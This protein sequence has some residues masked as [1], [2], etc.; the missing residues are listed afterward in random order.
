VT[1]WLLNV[2][3]FG[4]SDTFIP[5][6]THTF[7]LSISHRKALQGGVLSEVINLE[8]DGVHIVVENNVRPHMKVTHDAVGWLVKSLHKDAIASSDGTLP[9]IATEEYGATVESDAED[10]VAIELAD[11]IAAIKTAKDCSLLAW[12][13][14]LLYHKP[15]VMLDG[16]L[17]A[18]FNRNLVRVVVVWQLVQVPGSATCFAQLCR[19]Y[20]RAFALRGRRMV[21]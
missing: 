11:E 14:S 3:L 1:R 5:N 20:R 8:F 19:S 17:C 6:S 18:L 4:R 13:T 16:G 9:L 10:A 7:I 12:A 15:P 21:G 2:H